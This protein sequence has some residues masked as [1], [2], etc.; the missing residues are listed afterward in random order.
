ML[1]VY[2]S[3]IEE[4]DATKLDM[5]EVVFFRLSNQVERYLQVY[6]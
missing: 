5:L 4:S 2:E 1:G 6:G 3:D